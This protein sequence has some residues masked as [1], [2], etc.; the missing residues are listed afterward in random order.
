LT[1]N[2]EIPYPGMGTLDNGGVGSPVQ[3]MLDMEIRKSQYALKEQIEVSDATLVFEEI[4]QRTKSGEAFLTS[5]HTLDHYREL[6][7]STLFPLSLPEKMGEI[8]DDQRI[9][10]QC[11]EKWRANVAKWQPPAF[12]EDTKRALAG[13]L[14][15]AE[16]ELIG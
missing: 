16:K 3:F 7:T 15:R 10:D 2:P 6:W 12:R 5:D 14:E 13:V 9:L 1:G 11:E 4:C 8:G